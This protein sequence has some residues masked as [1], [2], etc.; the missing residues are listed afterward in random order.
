[1]DHAHQLNQTS[2]G[3]SLGT[4][5]AGLSTA[6]REPAVVIG[7]ITAA[8][9]AA[10]VLLFAF[11]TDFSADQQAALLAFATAVTPLIGALVTRSQVTPVAKAQAKIETAHA[12]GEAG[13]TLQVEA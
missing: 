9:D 3:A 1:M 12:V 7:A 13:E 11:V 8:V 2:L 10:I 5:T 4:S 6:A